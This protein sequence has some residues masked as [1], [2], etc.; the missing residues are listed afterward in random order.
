MELSDAAERSSAAR[1]TARRFFTVDPQEC[2][3]LRQGNIA[4]IHSAPTGERF[5]HGEEAPLRRLDH[6]T[7]HPSRRRFAAPQSL[8]QKEISILGLRQAVWS[9]A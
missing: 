2:G 1:I 8:T 9:G 5:P 7:S 3:A 4:L 6:E